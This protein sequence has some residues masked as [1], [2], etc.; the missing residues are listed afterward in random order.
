MTDDKKT[1]VGVF[2]SLVVGLGFVYFMAR[3]A[4]AGWNAG[5]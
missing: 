2:V 1:L 4:S 5:K 3:V